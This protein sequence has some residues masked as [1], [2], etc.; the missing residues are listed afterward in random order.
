MPMIRCERCGRETAGIQG[1]SLPL[2]GQCQFVWPG[3][4]KRAE[5][6]QIRTAYGPDPF[7][8]EDRYDEESGPDD[9]AD[10]AADL[11]IRQLPWTLT[12]K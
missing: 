11:R 9:V 10:D 7:D 6:R 8:M 5:A 2:C 12:T 3:G 1:E 4:G